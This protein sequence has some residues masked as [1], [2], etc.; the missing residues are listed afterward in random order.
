MFLALTMMAAV[1]CVAPGADIGSDDEALADGVDVF[2]LDR[3]EDLA[4]ELADADSRALLAKP[5]DDVPAKLT[6]A[7][8]TYPIELQLKGSASFRPLGDKPSFKIHFTTDDHP[9]GLKHLTLNNIVQ[10]EAM[11]HEVMGYRYFAALGLPAPRA[12]YAHV[13]LNGKNY[14]LYSNI[15]SYGKALIKRTFSDASDGAL[16]EGT[17]GADF[18]AALLD[19]FDLKFGDESAKARLAQ[20]A[21]AVAAPGDRLF[22]EDALVDTSRFVTLMAAETLLGHFDGYRVTLNNYYVY[23]A[24]S[25]PCTFMPSGIDNTFGAYD[26]GRALDRDIYVYNGVGVLFQKCIASERCLAQ[27]TEAMSKAVATFRSAGLEAI[28]DKATALTQSVVNADTKKPYSADRVRAAREEARA[29]VKQRPVDIELCVRS[30]KS[31]ASCDRVLRF[32]HGGDQRDG[33]DWSYGRYKAECGAGA[34]ISGLSVDAAAGDAFAVLC[35]VAD[36]AR[37]GAA[38]ASCTARVLTGTDARASISS[39]DWDFG[40]VKAECAD[41]EYVAGVSQLPTHELEAILCCPRPSGRVRASSHPL[42][43]A[44]A[45]ALEGATVGDWAPYHY[46][47]EC[48]ADGYVCGVSRGSNK[49][50]HALLCCH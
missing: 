24:P 39:G 11:V 23:C 41:G 50:A 29:F 17:I 33:N 9:A 27:Y 48:A 40:N 10:D 22:F 45:N 15:E 42:V 31:V 4:L 46:R 13:T 6:Y 21:A 8:H 47:A 5:R 16:F 36:T 32:G 20:I 3:V 19:K 28:L 34:A 30:G 12:G 43:F 14:G 37:F 2:S 7:G 18:T 44:H 26:T 38:R 1:G 35:S 49:R 25:K